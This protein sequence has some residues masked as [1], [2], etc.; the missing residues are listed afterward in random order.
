MSTLSTTRLAAKP[1]PRKLFISELKDFVISFEQQNKV[2]YVLIDFAVTSHGL[3]GR[4]ARLTLVPPGYPVPAYPLTAALSQSFKLAS[5]K[6]PKQLRLP[7]SLFPQ[8]LGPPPQ[9]FYVEVACGP[10]LVFSDTFP[11]L[12]TATATAPAPAN[13]CDCGEGLKPKFQSVAV[14]AGTGPLGPAYYGNP[15]YKPQFYEGWARLMAANTPG[16]TPVT[17]DERQVIEV[18]A[19]SEGPMDA[20]QSY[21]SEILSI[22]AM[23]KTISLGRGEGELNKQ[24]F[25]FKMQFPYQFKCLIGHCG[26]DVTDDGNGKYRVIYTQGSTPYEGPDLM[27]KVRAKNNSVDGKNTKNSVIDCFI[28]LCRND[29]FQDKQIYDYVVRL[30]S[31]KVLQSP[32]VDSKGALFPYL[33]GEYLRSN[34]GRAIALD[35]NVNKPTHTPYFLGA[36]LEQLFVN[37]PALKGTNP[38]TWAAADEQALIKLYAVYRMSKNFSKKANF[39]PLGMRYPM[40]RMEHG[41]ERLNSILDGFAR[42]QPPVDVKW[43][44]RQVVKLRKKKSKKKKKK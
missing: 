9:Q 3:K 23:Q 44:P 21:D 7:M 15:A 39:S 14:T 1:D 8:A 19:A 31:D 26:W 10:L 29:N 6:Q 32:L 11:L 22:G 43:L 37:R 27:T 40:S 20:V 4:A 33:L 35:E 34:V 24:L 42:Q 17:V 25:E 5:G 36:A 13:E 18:M 41:P 16:I 28:R 2:D 30:R 12:A 38:A